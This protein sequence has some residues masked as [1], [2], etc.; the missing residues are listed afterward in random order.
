VA[1]PLRRNLHEVRNITVGY[2]LIQP[3]DVDGEA[4]RIQAKP[5]YPSLAALI[6]ANRAKGPEE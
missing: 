5:H 2:V 6:A 1:L 3:A 4:R